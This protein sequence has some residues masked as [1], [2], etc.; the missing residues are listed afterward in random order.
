MAGG[1]PS[2]FLCSVKDHLL[3]LINSQTL[4][5]FLT[6]GRKQAIGKQPPV[7]TDNSYGCSQTSQRRTRISGQ[8]K[9]ECPSGRV[10][11]LAAARVEIA[12]S[13]F[14]GSLKKPGFRRMPI[15][16]ILSIHAKLGIGLTR[17]CISLTGEGVPGV[18]EH[19]GSDLS[20]L[21]TYAM[22]RGG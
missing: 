22:P 5:C 2:K 12:V 6:M 18:I 9:Q 15:T 16:R 7:D 19:N 10:D 17:F 13:H 1:P 4:C 8:K 11:C 3:G 20:S 21:G 14:A